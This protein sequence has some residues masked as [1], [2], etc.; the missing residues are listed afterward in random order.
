M[1]T[2][3]R[4]ECACRSDVGRVRER[5]EDVVAV[6]PERGWV[7]LADGMG[8]YRGGD[9]AA[10][11]GVDTVM[12]RLA[13]EAAGAPTASATAALLAGAVEAANAEILNEGLRRQELA[14]M[15]ATVVAAV[16]VDGHL[17][18]AHVGDSRL[19][20]FDRGRLIGLTRDHSWLQ[21]QVDAGM[22]SAAEARRMPYRGMLTR[23]LG[24]ADRVD[25]DVAVHPLQAEAL[26]LLCSD[27]LTD[28]LGDEDIAA[29][30]EAAASLE[31]AAD[32]LVALANARG[33]RDNISLILARAAG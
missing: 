3:V 24:V 4:L 33:G 22:I 10:R 29:V 8:G 25:V 21:E 30:L 28:M 26:Y 1:T 23:G 15:G 17:V 20:C 27:G 5:N 11:I 31:L 9:V 2:I 12:R 6:E 7:V 16:F 13:R 32:R 18:C 14:G 19:Y